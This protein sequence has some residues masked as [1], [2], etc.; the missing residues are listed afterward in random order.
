LRGT[1]PVFAALF[2]LLWTWWGLRGVGTGVD[3]SATARARARTCDAHADA[4]D[5]EKKPAM[6][7]PIPLPPLEAQERRELHA[8]HLPLSAKNLGESRG[9][10]PLGA[11]DESDSC[12]AFAEESI[13]RVV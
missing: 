5:H 7:R 3:G 2:K 12:C 6:S 1:F 8:V 9:R 4:G 10:S 11:Q 13:D